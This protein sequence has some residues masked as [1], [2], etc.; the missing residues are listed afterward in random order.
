MS[1]WDTYENRIE[2][3]GGTKRGTAFKREARFINKRLKDNLSFKSIKLYGQDCGYNIAD[4][5]M[6]SKAITKQLAIIKSD[7]LNE[8]YL[9]SQAGDDI[10]LGAL[11]EWEDNRW[12]VTEKDADRTVYSG[13]L[14][15]QCNF[16]LRWVEDDGK[17]YEQWCIISDGTKLEIVSA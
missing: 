5:E 17:I 11:V 8:K 3:R 12:L 6:S 1:C 7:N 16:L 13:A 15:E 14:M 2:T 4:E 10:E 9:Y